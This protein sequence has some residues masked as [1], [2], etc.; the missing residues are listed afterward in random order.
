[1]NF[2]RKILIIAGVA[3][4][5]AVLIP[6]IHHYQLRFTEASYIAKLE[7]R[8]EP[9][10]LA[11]VVPPPVPADQNSAGAFL[12]AAALFKADKSLLETNHLAG[13]KMI[14]RG[15]AVARFQQPEAEGDS[16]TN[17]WAEV[18]A[19]VRQNG[20]AFELLQQLVAH[21]DL[22]FQ[23]QYE[24]GVGAGFN[25]NDTHLAEIKRTAQ[26]LAT[27]SIS[28]LHEGDTSGAVK[29]LRA[30]LGLTK[31]LD[32]EHLVISELVQIAMASIASTVTW[33]VLQST[34]VTDEHLAQLA[35]DWNALDFVQ[36]DVNALEMDRVMHQMSLVQWR[37]S[38][39]AMQQVMDGGRTPEKEWFL[40]EAQD[41]VP[42]FMWRYWWSYPDEM[43]R[44]KGFEAMLEAAR[45]MRTNHAF[46]AAIQRQT[47][48]L[49]TLGL[50]KVMTESSG[51]V[52]QDMHTLLSQ[53]IPGLSSIMHRLMRI[54]VARQI[55]ITA[56]A[57]K[58][59]QLK[60]GGYPPDLNS[61]VPDFVS[62]LPF[63]PVDGQALRYRTEPDGTFLLY[64][65]G[66]NGVDDGG[67]PSLER[68]VKGSIS[69]FWQMDLALDWV[70]PQ[71]VAQW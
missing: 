50:E 17:S 38:N 9:M 58:R 60:H 45:D 36:A 64:S 51:L 18:A 2:R 12:Q 41:A 10:K 48:E 21:P 8:G 68:G 20:K 23:F 33:E 65:V 30:L 67:N 4:C 24:R 6:V 13:M 27:A 32:D 59:Y 70:W 31:A 16:A 49:D 61:L 40:F 3:V 54:E 15:K 44:L 39:R 56:I 66:E 37:A 22:D 46:E 28:D 1:M 5:A 63:D 55:T 53:S 69:M 35:N 43:R 57:L 34:N 52:N 71:S 25:F 29:N 19:A 62:E 47:R 42:I 11:Q 14:G 26:R 7:A